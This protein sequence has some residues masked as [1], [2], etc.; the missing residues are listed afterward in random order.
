[1]TMPT[2]TPVLLL[3]LEVDALFP[4]L[5][6]MPMP[7]V[8]LYDVDDVADGGNGLGNESDDTRHDS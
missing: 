7:G 4:V 8:R 6:S 2:M 3:L 1:M 5:E